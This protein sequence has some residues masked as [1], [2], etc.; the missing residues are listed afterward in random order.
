MIK[1]AVGVLL[2][3]VLLAAG[4]LCYQFY[5]TKRQSEQL[6]FKAISMENLQDGSYE[7]EC[8]TGLV[9]VQLRVQVKDDMVKSI[10]LLQHDNGM[11][12]PAERLLADIQDKNSTAV[13]DVSSATISSRAIR[14]AAQNA[15]EKAAGS[16]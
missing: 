12:K 6:D 4:F 3:V 1:R 9:Y 13:D 10:Q 7:G 14:M 11:G 8:R 5:Q 2:A 15:L 16:K